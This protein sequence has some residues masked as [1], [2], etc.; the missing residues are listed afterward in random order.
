MSAKLDTMPR[1]L[2]FLMFCGDQHGKAEEAIRWYCSLFD[3]SHVLDINLYGPDDAEPAGT[4]RTASFSL[5]GHTIR[6][7]DSGGAHQFTFTPAF[8]FWIEC[9]SDEEIERLAAAFREGGQ[10]LMPMDN[11]GFSEKFSWIQDRYGVSW[12]L[13]LQG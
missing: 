7:I 9:S 6:A 2:P 12:Q 3:D 5:G 4:V 13:N 8:S 1:T 10:E 11:Y